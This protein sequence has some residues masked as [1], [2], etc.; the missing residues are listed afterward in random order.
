MR[1][2]SPALLAIAALVSALLSLPAHA[3]E[4]GDA[5]GLDTP[6][7]NAPSLIH[8]AT[9]SIQSVTDDALSLIGVRYRRGGTSPKTGF[10]CSGFVQHVFREGMDLILPRTARE[11]SKTGEPIKK[12]ELQPGDLVFFNTMRRA[13]SH[14]GIYLGDGQ[15]IHAPHTGGK[16]RIEDLSESYWA[17]RY[18]GARRV[19]EE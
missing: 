17:K 14:V 8:K 16:V 15:F 18:E 5:R 10:D 4:G 2:I 9:A 7:T 3:Q 11:I 13:F 1:F 6:D 12:S 19:V